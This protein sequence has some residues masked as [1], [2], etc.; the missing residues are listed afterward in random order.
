MKYT[1]AYANINDAT[2]L[3]S[4]NL[5]VQYE[6]DTLFNFDP[7]V[8]AHHLVTGLVNQNYKRAADLI[9]LVRDERG[10]IAYTWAR[11]GERSIWS[12]DEILLVRM[13]HVDPA[14][15]TR[16]RV[17]L[18][19]D[20]LEIWEGFAKMRQIPVIASTT[21]RQEQTAFL[22]LH[23]NAGYTLRGSQAYKRVDLTDKPDAA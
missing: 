4:L 17:M 14:L 11:A 1:W 22:K 9:V 3:M 20:M 6:V 23:T 13:A 8:L 10:I 5:K 7:N 12:D 21:L 2:E 16:E 18:I 19:K 15:S